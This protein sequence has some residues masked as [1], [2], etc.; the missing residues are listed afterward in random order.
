MCKVKAASKIQAWYRCWKARREYLALLTAVKI[1]QGCFWTKLARTRYCLCCVGVCAGMGALVCLC[2]RCVQACVRPRV[3]V[4]AMCGHVCALVCVY[5]C[6]VQ[7]CVCPCV[8]F[9]STVCRC[10]R[11]CVRPCVC[12][13]PPCVG[14]CVPLCVFVS[15]VCGCVCTLVCLSPPCVGVCV[16]PCVSLYEVILLIDFSFKY[17]LCLICMFCFVGVFSIN[18]K[19]YL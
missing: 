2:L 3:S 14:V 9:V 18:E 4:S 19:I 11:A 16:S 8:F 1:V 6:R 10:V 17:H 15:A 7:A 12:L 13:S 5:L